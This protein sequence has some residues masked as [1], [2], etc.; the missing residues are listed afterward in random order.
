MVPQ[1]GGESDG[2]EQRHGHHLQPGKKSKAPCGGT[3]ERQR[4]IAKMSKGE[5]TRGIDGSIKRLRS[6]LLE[7]HQ[8]V[9]QVP[10]PKLRVPSGISPADRHA[11]EAAEDHPKEH[12]HKRRVV[13][14]ANA[15]FC[16]LLV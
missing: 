8:E 14:L 12:E 13:P 9:S 1:E 16:W 4:E 7:T 6:A 2:R 11:V 15:F 3:R 10:L 5:A